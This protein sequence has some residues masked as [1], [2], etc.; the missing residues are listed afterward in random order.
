MIRFRTLMLLLPAVLPLGCAMVMPPPGQSGRADR[1]VVTEQGETAVSSP[2]APETGE[3]EQAAQPIP[4]DTPKARPEPP[5]PP[6]VLALVNEAEIDR[7]AGRLDAAAATLER[8]IRIQPRNPRLWKQ[9]AELR[10]EQHQP[11]LAEDLAKKSNLLAAGNPSLLQENWLL[12]AK[13][14]RL[15]GDEKGALAAESKASRF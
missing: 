12:I 13:A 7:N 11:G 3:P 6:A 8:A 1:S 4:A 5:S 10:L 15:K 9:L 2:T 14:R